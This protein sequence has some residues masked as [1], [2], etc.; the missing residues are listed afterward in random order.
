MIGRTVGNYVI[1][2]QVGEG[3]MGIVYV[4]EHPQ[5]SRRVAVKVLHPGN[6]RAPELVH[7]FFTEARAASEI[8]NEHIVDVLDFGQLPDGSPYLVMEWL[9]GQSLAAL[10]RDTPVLAPARAARIVRGVTQ[11]LRAAHGKGVVHRDLKPD[12]VFLVPRDSDPDFVKVLDF[13]IAKLIAAGASPTFQTQTGAIMGTPAYMSPEQCR[14]A[15]EID[16]RS[17]IYSVG[18]MAYQMVTG[19]LPFAADSLGELLFKHLG[20]T[21]VPPDAILPSLPVGLSA[22]IDR[23]LAK[24]PDKRPTL[25][26]LAAAMDAVE[27]GA[28]P[29]RG[30]ARAVEATA[31]TQAQL[32]VA[33]TTLGGSASELGIEHR[34]PTV[35]AT[36][37]KG[38]GI[39]VAALVGG[40]AVGAIVY[41]LSRPAAHAPAASAVAPVA[42]PPVAAPPVVAP[43]VTAPHAAPDVA[44]DVAPAEA[45][46]SA[47]PAAPAVESHAHATKHHGAT[48]RTSDAAEKGYRGSRLDLDTDFPGGESHARAKP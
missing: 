18:V 37:R 28:D 35:T 31:A 24:E 11:A 32:P 16:D 26:E 48:A 33:S 36:P 20:E 39:V 44:P 19:R 34:V 25:A 5:I 2:A 41:V 46:K 29:A 3:G 12:N 15:K 8:R 45:A 38:G 23:A 10:L 14:G 6:D 17:D 42:A 43:V 22:I 27:S 7:R 30:D 4:A 1:R 13:G 47:S 40:L 21:P 9:E